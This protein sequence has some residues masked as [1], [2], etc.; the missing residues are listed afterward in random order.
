MKILLTTGI[1]PPEIGGP[2]TYAFLIKTELEKRG[3]S[4]V[5]L[6]FRRVRSFPSGIRHMLYAVLAFWNMISADIVLT[7]DTVSVGFPSLL[8]AKITNTPIVLRVPGD[9]AW[10]QGVQR[11]GVKEGIDDFQKKKYGFRIE[12][13]RAIQ[14]FVVRNVTYV[15]TPSDYFKNIVLAWGA[16]LDRTSRIYNGVSLPDFIEKRIFPQATLVSAGR[17]VP[18][19]GFDRL[20]EQMKDIN[21]HLV[22]IGDGEDGARLKKLIEEYHVSEKVTLL[23]RLPR[24]E[25]LSW[26]AGAAL[27]VLPSSFE[28]FSFQL[29]EA[30]TVGTPV[31]ALRAGNL[32]EIIRHGEN[33]F[34]IDKNE[35]S[36]LAPVLNTILQDA[37]LR[38]RIRRNA[39]HDAQS[40]SVQTTTDQLE[41]LFQSLV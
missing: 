22:V 30:M 35:I 6:P 27:F 13:L 12:F 40:F 25:L 18:W 36:T 28:S 4:V 33:G 9:F 3:H 14:R 23:G 37:P 17:F 38:D 5:V 24:E 32:D 39:L 21:A 29:V 26:I 19:K 15:I 11:F 16:R 10:E 8:A 1:Y 34:L 7:Q 2:A 31:V 20:I 41:T